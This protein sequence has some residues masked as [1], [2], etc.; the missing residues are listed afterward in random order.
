VKPKNKDKAEIFTYY[1]RILADNIPPA[2]PEFKFDEAF[3]RKHRFDFAFPEYKVAV[4][5][6]GN[7]WK[8]PGGGKHMQDADLEKYNIAAMLGWR[9][10][11]FSPEMLINDPDRH[12][13]MIRECLIK[14]ISSENA[15][16]DVSAAVERLVRMPI[17]ASSTTSKPKERRSTRNLTTSGT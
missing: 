11:R 1:W 15:V 3:D 5:V 4:E 14:K 17:T 12:I 8:V 10:L 16:T 9:V 2:L 6:E 13:G 7:A